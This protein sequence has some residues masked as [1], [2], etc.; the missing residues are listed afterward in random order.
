M[1]SATL[2]EV[3]KHWVRELTEIGVLLVA[4][5]I[6]A[7]ILFGDAVPFL[8]GSS[9]VVSRITTLI[10]E[11]WYEWIVGVVAVGVSVYIFNKKNDI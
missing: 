11:L 7:A 6:V 1:N 2:I 8:A 4:L 10:S 5:S 3:T 9:G